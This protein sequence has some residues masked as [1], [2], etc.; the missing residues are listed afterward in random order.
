MPPPPQPVRME[1]ESRAR[2]AER[3]KS[4]RMVRPFPS[5]DKHYLSR[6][7]RRNGP[8]VPE[9]LL[10]FLKVWWSAS[11]RTDSAACLLFGGSGRAIPS[12]APVSVLVETGDKEL[13]LL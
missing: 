12:V 11:R 6:R 5:G 3:T 13:D 4:A 10:G 8:V 9:L 2:I 7:T 1:S